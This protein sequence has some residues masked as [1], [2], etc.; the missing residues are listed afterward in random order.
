MSRAKFQKHLFAR[1]NKGAHENLIILRIFSPNY[2]LI[3]ISSRR[4]E[5]KKIQQG[6]W[7]LKGKTAQT[8]FIEASKTASSVNMNAA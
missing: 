6:S 4:H 5:K 7:M 8:A 1:F 3:S 2:Y